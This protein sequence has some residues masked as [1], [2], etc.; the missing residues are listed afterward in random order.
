MSTVIVC[1]DGASNKLVRGF[2]AVFSSKQPG[3]VWDPSSDSLTALR[4]AQAMRRGDVTQHERRQVWEA[5]QD[6]I[7]ETVTLWDLQQSIYNLAFLSA[8]EDLEPETFGRRALE[9]KAELDALLNSMADAATICV[10]INGTALRMKSTEAAQHTAWLL[11]AIF[12]FTAALP[13]GKFIP[14][15]VCDE[16]R[17]STSEEE[18]LK[19]NL[20]LL[21]SLDTP[22][23][24]FFTNASDNEAI[25]KLIL[26]T[27]PAVLAI[28]ERATKARQTLC[29]TIHECE[30][31]TPSSG[32]TV[33]P[34]T[35]Q[36]ALRIYPK[37]TNQLQWPL[38][39]DLLDDE[40]PL[41]DL[42]ALKT[43]LDALEGF[44]K[45]TP[46]QL[47]RVAFQSWS[48]T[49]PKVKTLAGKRLLEAVKK[50]AMDSWKARQKVRLVNGLFIGI[51]GLVI[52]FSIVMA[53]STR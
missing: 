40:Q 24:V 27:N 45:K 52:L 21:S 16:D 22:P 26:A 42:N 14:L 17:P 4:T 28:Y 47:T 15:I 36:K 53:L 8:E 48:A 33:K 46:V 38:A 23:K 25:I 41:P 34:G 44:V 43:D 51:V 49:A 11:R 29:K 32:V 10:A 39:V 35:V 19:T 12:R 18:W 5:R 20:P 9:N 6:Q 7:T 31:W 13:C 30:T 3:W 50:H 37:E 2:D 1:L